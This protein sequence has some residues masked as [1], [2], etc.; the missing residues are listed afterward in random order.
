MTTYSIEPDHETLHGYFS[1]DLA[2]VLTIESGDTVIFRTLDAGWGLEPPPPPRK[3]FELEDKGRMNGHALCGPIY[4]NGAKQGM[5]LEVQI[6]EV[7]PGDY[8]YTAA[9]RFPHPINEALN[10]VEGA[11]ELFLLWEI[12]ADK[13]TARN[14]F[15]N[16]VNLHPFPGVLGMPP[17]EEGNHHTAPPRIWGGNLDCKELVSGTTLYLPIPVEG[18]L[19]SAGDGHARQGDGEVSVTAIECPLERLSLTFHVRE[20]VPL[21]T[22]RAR[23][24]G[25]WITFGLHENLWDAT[26]MAL[27]AM[28]DLMGEQYGIPR[29]QALGLASVVVDLR[30]TQIANGTLGVHAFLPDGAVR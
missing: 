5:T 20:D 29:Q 2:P 24:H 1:R 6:N 21:K 8:G 22:P 30:I 13:K 18:G 17:P 19:F 25:G 9:G 23:V 28:L 16:E 3:K 7:V 12:A 10:L 11:E 14:Q 26:V 15:G 27:D 4:F